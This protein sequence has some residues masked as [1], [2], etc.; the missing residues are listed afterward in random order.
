MK[1]L[2]RAVRA[3]SAA[4]ILGLA[5]CSGSGTSPQTPTTVNINNDVLQF[6]VGTA[7]IFG[8]LGAGGGA[9]VGLNV[10]TTFRQ[11]ASGSQAAGDS[12]ALVSSPT[13]TLPGAIT[14]AL[15]TAD[16]FYSTITTGPSSTEQGGHSLTS[17]AQTGS[18][19]PTTFG[20]SGGDFG[21]GLEPF[22]YNEGGAPDSVAPYPVP[23]YD[24]L[25]GTKAGDPNLFIPWGGPPAFDPAGDGT[26]VRD[27][28]VPAG[29]LG[30]PEG[31]D[32]FE[33]I[34]PTSGTYQLS[35]AVPANSGTVTKQANAGLNGAHV[36][37]SFPAPTV[38]LSGNGG[39]T[40]T[41]GLPSG[42]TEAYIQVTDVGPTQNA[43]GTLVSCNGSQ[44]T[45][46]YYTIVARAPG[47]YT[48]P[49]NDG[50]QKAQSLCTAAAN[51]AASGAAA[52]G[53]NFT[54]QLIGFDYPW[55]EASYP[56]SNGNPAPAIVGGAGQT[57][58][59]VSSAF[60]F[61]PAGAGAGAAVRAKLAI[62][63]A[64]SLPHFRR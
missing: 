13:L 18:I 15:G 8:D 25:T 1:K 32:V 16:G 51:T 17:T 22:N 63:P 38:A 19:A 34:A 61:A 50:T 40:I 46:T 64:T 6:A 10:A 59:T 24:A 12:A 60:G 42:V 36:L 47:S 49:S 43:A 58:I 41:V 4:A 2:N 28:S 44:V 57:D 7:N 52:P 3:T 53:D 35:V 55:F 23:L 48:L 27:E 21:L 20:T 31:L 54:V 26:G 56:N 30:V 14:A 9:K 62:R 33:S 11:P 5:A 37:G 45:P 39:A 29:T